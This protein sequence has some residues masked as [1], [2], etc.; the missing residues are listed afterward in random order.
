MCAVAERSEALEGEE[1]VR[2]LR[3]LQ[4]EHVRRV[5]GEQA[6]DD[7]HAQPTELMFQVAMEKGMAGSG[8]ESSAGN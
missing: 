2:A 5:L 8:P 1:L 4:A 3:L 7:R 6:L